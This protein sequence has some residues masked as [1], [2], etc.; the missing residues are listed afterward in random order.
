MPG[1]MLG[2]DAQARGALR[3]V[4]DLGFR[5]A[6]RVAHRMLRSYWAIRKP[7]TQGA[8]V[9]VWHDGEILVVKNSY[10][11]EFTL[12]GGYVRSGES[13]EEAGA[14]ELLEEVGIEVPVERISLAYHAVKSFEH[15]DDDVT[16]V[17]TEVDVRP[18][19]TVDNREVVWAGFRSP[20]A[21]LA[22]PVVPHLREYL[23]GK[24][25]G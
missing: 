5:T 13:D 3:G 25:A 12:P 22:L 24:R 2:A 21:A 19:I 4:V 20:G 1:V 16:I 7:H 17:E 10:R 18:T 8:L 23:E 6:Y 14:R 11:R 15:R 9:A